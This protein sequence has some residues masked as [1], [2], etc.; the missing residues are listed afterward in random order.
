MTCL[1]TQAT[2]ILR[3]VLTKLHSEGITLNKKKCV[4]WFLK[5]GLRLNR[6]GSKPQRMCLCI[7]RKVLA[8]IFE[9][10]PTFLLKFWPC[11]DKIFI[12]DELPSLRTIKYT[13][14]A[15]TNC[16]VRSSFICKGGNMFFLST[17]DSWRMFG[18]L[19]SE[20]ASYKIWC[21]MIE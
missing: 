1:C 13:G 21:P 6:I 10:Q 3:N 18:S 4:I 2:R 11:P 20:N 17:S 15:S 7:S 14:K 16:F 9:W 5:L 19:G 12:F 8:N